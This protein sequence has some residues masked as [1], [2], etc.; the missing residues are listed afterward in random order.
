MSPDEI[1]LVNA[2]KKVGYEFRFRSNKEIE[3]HIGGVKQKYRLLKLFPFTSERKRMS[4]VVQDPEDQN[5]VYLFTKGADSM[6]KSLSVG[7]FSSHF[8]FSYIDKFARKGYRTLLVGIKVIHY[9]EYL[10]WEKEYDQ[11]NNQIDTDNKDIL[12][13]LV[14][15]IEKDLFLLGTTGLEDKLQENVHE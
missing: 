12:E 1:T 11:I 9:H 5:F 3:I 10:E 7:Q 2:A 8:D 14:E 6:M 15:E 13:E 4:I